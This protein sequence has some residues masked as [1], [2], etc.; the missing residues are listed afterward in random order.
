MGN[1]A[2]ESAS[3][4]LILLHGIGAN[5]CSWDAVRAALPEGARSVAIDLPGHGTRRSERFGLDRAI[6]AVDHA[7]SEVGRPAVLVGWSL[8]GYVALA[9]GCR[10][11]KNVAG[12][13]LI[14]S[15]MIPNIAVRIVFSAAARVARLSETAAMRRLIPW[16]ARRRYGRQAVDGTL[17]CGI[18]PGNGLRALRLIAR[19]DIAGWLDGI[20][21]DVLIL[22]GAHDALFR[23]QDRRIAQRLRRAS[24]RTMD[25]AGHLAPMTSPGDV[26]QAVGD[27]IASRQGRA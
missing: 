3:P 19:W 1:G 20:Q 27:F 16:I 17:R 5:R 4:S 6:R 26:A 25:R 10:R 13:V 24:L 9:Y 8:G 21:C 7:L 2:S 22:N 11:P 14:G 23:W 18:E 15:S 12:I